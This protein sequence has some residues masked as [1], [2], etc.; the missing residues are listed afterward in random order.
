MVHYL[1]CRIIYYLA[2]SMYYSV[3]ININDELEDIIT[4][5]CLSVDFNEYYKDITSLEDW[6]IE[7]IFTGY[8]RSL[9]LC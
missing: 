3:P 1:N 4:S 7:K 8:N 5:F 6:K 9:M 2:M